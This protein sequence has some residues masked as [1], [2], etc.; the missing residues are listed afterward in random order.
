M[1]SKKC[2]GGWC[3]WMRWGWIP[4]LQGRREHGISEA[5]LKVK[6]WNTNPSRLK[7]I[8]IEVKNDSPFYRA[9]K[10]IAEPK[11]SQLSRGSSWWA[12]VATNAVVVA[13]PAAVAAAKFSVGMSEFFFSP[14]KGC[15]GAHSASKMHPLITNS[16]I[17]TQPHSLAHIHTHKTQKGK[18][19]TQKMQT[20]HR[21]LTHA[22]VASVRS[23]ETWP[24]GEIEL[25]KMVYE[26]TQ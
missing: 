7:G 16:H 10:S 8:S 23:V 25:A 9:A 18:R 12:V 17:H 22:L 2:W 5:I 21:S 6:L 19:K 11:G 1:G 15:F 20:Q 26:C 4:S 3:G 14:I 24:K 13:E